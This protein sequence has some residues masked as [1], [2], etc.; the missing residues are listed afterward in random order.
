MAEMTPANEN[1]GHKA[2]KHSF[3]LKTW[4]GRH[5]P[6]HW[7]ARVGLALPLA[8]EYFLARGDEL[9][10]LLVDGVVEHGRL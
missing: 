7:W 1:C 4:T 8:H 3:S 9:G 6:A 10:E 2:V 5:H